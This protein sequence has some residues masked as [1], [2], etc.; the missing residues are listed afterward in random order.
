MWRNGRA[1]N[2]LTRHPQRDTLLLSDISFSTIRNRRALHFYPASLRLQ[3]VAFSFVSFLRLVLR[4]KE[5]R[6]MLRP[7]F[8][9][10]AEARGHRRNRPPP[11]LQRARA[12][13]R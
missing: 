5:R 6:A 7:P 8:C 1:S 11:V 10:S 3:G 9:E 13:F 12:I 4:A 2:R